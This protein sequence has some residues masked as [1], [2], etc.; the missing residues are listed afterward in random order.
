MAASDADIAGLTVTLQKK[1]IQT[2]RR[3]SAKSLYIERLVLFAVYGV[4]RNVAQ[5][6]QDRGALS[7]TAYGH[8][9]SLRSRA[10]P[11]GVSRCSRQEPGLSAIAHGHA[12]RRQAA[13]C[14]TC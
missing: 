9:D 7:T 3:E 2:P 1:A 13:G 6:S 5:G 11:E 12:S 10:N 8:N 14:L 4:V